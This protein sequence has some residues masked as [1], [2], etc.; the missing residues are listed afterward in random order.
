MKQRI[1]T[2][3]DHV[4]YE[5]T[6]LAYLAD[7]P[8]HFRC[9]IYIICVSGRSEISTGAQNFILESET[10]LIFLTGTLLQRGVATPDFRVKMVKIPESVL[11]EA[12]LPIDTPYFNYANEHPLYHHTEDE[13]SRTTWM[14]V[15]RWMDIAKMLFS[16]GYRSQFMEQQESNFIQGLLLWLFNTVPEKIEV[17]PRYSR[18]Q[19]LCHQFM[20]LIR[21]YGAME[22]S[23][24]FYAEKLCVSSRYLHKATVSC[25]EGK[26]PKQLIEEQLLAEVKVLLN[27]PDLTVT[28][29]AAQ[30][31]FP[32]Q[33][34]LT[35]FFKRHTS[36][37]PTRYRRSR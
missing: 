25:L 12:I 9:G 19:L 36:V 11:M 8:C 21:E 17:N 32:D 5:E 20:Q 14:Q 1:L 35:R 16:G 37:S 24:S 6:D 22:H 33:S 27:D 30:L 31:N 2:D 7:A 29:I 34:Y 23:A 3:T 13:R 26:T 18:L 4:R 10:E 28:E 15:S